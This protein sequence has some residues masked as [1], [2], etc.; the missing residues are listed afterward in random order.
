MRGNELRR[1]KGKDEKRQDTSIG[2]VCDT[3]LGYS[4]SYPNQRGLQRDDRGGGGGV[5][6]L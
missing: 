3:L 6:L 2:T 5:S 4:A 1:T